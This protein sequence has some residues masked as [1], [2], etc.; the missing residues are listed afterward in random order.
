M[1]KPKKDPK[2]MTTAEL[3][4]YS[5][6][7]VEHVKKSN[8]ESE[9]RVKKAKEE[10]EK[11]MDEYN[12]YNKEIGSTSY[13]PNVDLSS[14]SPT[15]GSGKTSTATPSHKPIKKPMSVPWK[16]IIGAGLVGLGGYGLYKHLSNKNKKKG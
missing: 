5:E 14:N 15:I 11:A 2:K 16:P 12:K 6:E 13:N 7:L 9:A 10:F 3:K 1:P 8:K 4:E